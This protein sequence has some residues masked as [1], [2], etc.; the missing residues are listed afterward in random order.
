MGRLL[1][2]MLP[3][4]LMKVGKS[5]RQKKLVEFQFCVHDPA[6]WWVQASNL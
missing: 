6:W 5:M 4:L 2:M 1:Q 3:M